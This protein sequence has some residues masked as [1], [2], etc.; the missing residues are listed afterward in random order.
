[1]S[2][3]VYETNTVILL[4]PPMERSAFSVTRL[5]E[6]LPTWIFFKSLGPFIK[7]LYSIWQ[8]V[9]PTLANLLYFWANLQC[10]KLANIE[11]IN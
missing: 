11:Q 5:G 6:I 4:Q 10:C 9:Q 1:M 2:I 7:G 3:K 8:N